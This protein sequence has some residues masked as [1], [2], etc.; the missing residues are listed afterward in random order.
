MYELMVVPA[1]VFVEVRG[2]LE[3]WDA[4]IKQDGACNLSKP[5]RRSENAIG[6][7]CK[8]NESKHDVNVRLKT[9]SPLGSLQ[10]FYTQHDSCAQGPVAVMC[11][12]AYIRGTRRIFAREA[13]DKLRCLDAVSH[14]SLGT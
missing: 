6:N 2:S 4:T 13:G 9:S 12:T 14:K 3:E 5:C 1:T 11:S 10:S 8:Y 7:S